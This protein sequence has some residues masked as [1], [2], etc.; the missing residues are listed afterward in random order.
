MRNL[1]LTR[2]GLLVILGGYV[3]Q[4]PATQ[5]STLQG[6]GNPAWIKLQQ[7]FQALQHT[8]SNRSLRILQ[9][10]DSH[11]AGYAFTG[12]LRELLLQRFPDGGP[13]LLAPGTLRAHDNAPFRL[14]QTDGW[15]SQRERTPSATGNG[16][17]GGF[18]AYSQR[19]YQLLTYVLPNGNPHAR[20]VLYTDPEVTD[21][22]S[23]FKV[24]HGQKETPPLT[25]SASGRMLYNL[26]AG[27]GQLDIL[28]RNSG[29][30][31]RLR[32]VSLLY[33]VRGVSYCSIGVNGASFNILQEWK[34]ASAGQEMADFN[35]ELLILAFGTNDVLSPRFSREGFMETLKQ[36]TMWTREFASDAAVLIVLPPG[37]PRHA[38]RI[39]Q[40]LTILRELIGSVATHNGWR[41]WDWQQAL[42]DPNPSRS[43][44]GVLYSRDG[45]HLT[46]NGY[47]YSAQGLFIALSAYF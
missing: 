44:S 21:Q 40:N 46:A 20:L 5:A 1:N 32:G 22:P 2:W 16:V 30:L 28:S 19:P 15:V 3:Q 43:T 34:G 31:P 17:L 4:L 39:Q 8:T 9:L 13:G 6:T 14:H 10:G 33:E 36:T 45:V 24:F 11:T 42:N 12:R 25:R 23:R 29:P 35:P 27:N 41:V 26:P 7:H 38:P 47:R 18:V 37:M